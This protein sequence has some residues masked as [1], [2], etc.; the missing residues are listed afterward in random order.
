MQANR[1][2]LRDWEEQD[3]QPWLDW[4]R[5]SPKWRETDGPYFRDK[6]IA[7]LEGEID[8]RRSMIRAGMFEIPRNS[9][10]IA[11]KESN[12]MIGV[13][14]CYWIG[15]ETNWLAAGLDIYDP[16]Y[17]G[18]GI[19]AE[20]LTLWITY[21]F[22]NYPKIVRLDLQ[23]WSGNTGM[24]RLA[25]KLGFKEEARFRKARIVKDQYYDAI[26]YGILREEWENP[27]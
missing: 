10:M 14:S 5:D 9:L 21:L 1:I 16:E 2:I 4:H 24:M 25:E 19:G 8:I 7:E 27:A 15:R 22:E 11:L 26:G 13:V 12:Q 23:T 20:A 6:P 3:L 18:K 17:W